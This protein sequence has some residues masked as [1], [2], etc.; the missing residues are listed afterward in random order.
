VSAAGPTDVWDDPDAA[1]ELDAAE[2]RD[3]ATRAEAAG[4]TRGRRVLVIPDGLA[5]RPGP[6]GTTLSSVKPM[7]LNAVARRGAVRRVATTPEGLAPGSEVG[8]P[9][10]LGWSPTG[11]VSRGR[12]DAAAHGLHEPHGAVV[13]RVD[14]RHDDG[15]P[16]P[17]LAPSALTLL[18]G[19]DEALHVEHLSAHR[20]LVWG[21]RTPTLPRRLD[22]DDLGSAHGVAGTHDPDDLPRFQLWPDGIEPPPILDDDTVVVCAPRS[23]MAGVAR[24]MGA[25][26]VH[27]AG[28]TGRPGTSVAAKARAAV[29]LLRDGIHT[30]VV[31]VGSPDE[32]AHARDPQAKRL[33]MQKIDRDLIAPLAAVVLDLGATLAICPDHGTDP[34][35]GEHLAD[36]VPAVLWGPGVRPSGPDRVTEEAVAH[37]PVVASPWG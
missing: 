29:S 7:A 3:A 19:L 21:H 27:P 5:E 17:E 24:L 4:H 23:T 31:H 20:F 18:R 30:V 34:R 22:L 26:T 25:A 15:R 9:T 1:D 36:P 10:L 11:V 13:H 14:V 33:E 6:L 37:A 8:L 32:A 28:A 2:D 35:T 16:W 12:V